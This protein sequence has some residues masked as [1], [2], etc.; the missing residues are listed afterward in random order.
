MVPKDPVSRM[1]APNVIAEH[2]EQWGS[3]GHG[4]CM[5]VGTDDDPGKEPW[6][7]ERLAA[8]DEEDGVHQRVSKI[9]ADGPALATPI[10]VDAEWEDE[11]IASIPILRLQS[12][13]TLTLDDMVDAPE[14]AMRLW[15]EWD[16]LE[17]IDGALYRRRS[18]KRRRSCLLY[19]SDAA[20]E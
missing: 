15:S 2:R 20:D 18:V 14:K 17:V 9:P 16:H 4:W 7:V 3:P 11:N 6:L 19:T 5:V 8:P 13:A 10:I 1:G 12:S